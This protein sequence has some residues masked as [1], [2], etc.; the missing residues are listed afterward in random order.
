M[1]IHKSLNLGGGIQSE[2]SVYTRRERLDKLM[3]SGDF[4]EGSNPLGLPKVRTRYRTVTKRQLKALAAAEREA[5]IAEAEAADAAQRAAEAA[6]EALPDA[7]S[8]E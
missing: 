8:G 4:E 5:A 3:E 6:G 2:R 1:S 7:S